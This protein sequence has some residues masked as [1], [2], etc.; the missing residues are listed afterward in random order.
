[1]VKQ[2]EHEM[3]KA[4]RNNKGWRNT[5]W[6]QSLLEE[7]RKAIDKLIKYKGICNMS[8][9]QEQALRKTIYCNGSQNF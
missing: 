3:A 7:Y 5:G 6:G 2:C 4:E 8:N 9:E 1:M